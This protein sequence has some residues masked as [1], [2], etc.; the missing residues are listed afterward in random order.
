MMGA[1][2]ACKNLT[3]VMG[4]AVLTAASM[5]LAG[6]TSTEPDSPRA[7][8]HRVALE[9]VLGDAADAG[10]AVGAAQKSC[11]GVMLSCEPN[12]FFQSAALQ[13]ADATAAGVCERFVGLATALNMSDWFAVGIVEVAEPPTVAVMTEQC[14]AKLAQLGDPV[15][16]SAVVPSS[17]DDVTV[18]VS[19][20]ATNEND[21]P[22]FQLMVQSS[23]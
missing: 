11:D 6:C 13:P 5:T 8:E 20:Q 12:D 16:F 7:A 21:T 17:T 10:F 3:F 22:G 2:G 4:A 18:Y 14:A 19:I 9:A 15:T 23:E 1:V